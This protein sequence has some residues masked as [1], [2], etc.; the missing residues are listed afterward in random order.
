MT[1]RQSRPH[2][3]TQRLRQGPHARFHYRHDRASVRSDGTAVPALKSTNSFLSKPCERIR[4]APDAQQVSV[5]PHDL[6]RP[7][8][9]KILMGID[10]MKWADADSVINIISHVYAYAQHIWIRK[11]RAAKKTSAVSVN[12]TGT[13]EVLRRIMKDVSLPPKAEVYKPLY[14]DGIRY[15][16]LK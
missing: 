16:G 15:S 10:F 13:E 3:L 2:G 9:Q 12:R 7:Q 1:S 4:T 11:R 5:F 14:W 6:P 8:R